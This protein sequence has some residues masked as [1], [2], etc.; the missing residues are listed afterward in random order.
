MH[1]DTITR[2]VKLPVFPECPCSKTEASPHLLQLRVSFPFHISHSLFSLLFGI[3][4][5]FSDGKLLAS[6]LITI[7]TD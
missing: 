4:I 7:L 1:Q 2:R 6:C 5:F 3:I